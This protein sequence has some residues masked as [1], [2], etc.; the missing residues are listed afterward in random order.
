MKAERIL[1]LLAVL[2]CV[3]CSDNDHTRTDEDT[4]TP[5]TI[6]DLFPRYHYYEYLYLYQLHVVLENTTTGK[7]KEFQINEKGGLI[8]EIG[9]G[10]KMPNDAPY[11]FC[12]QFNAVR[13]IMRN[14]VCYEEVLKRYPDYFYYECVLRFENAYELENIETKEFNRFNIHEA[15]RMLRNPNPEWQIPQKAPYVL[16]FGSSMGL[17]LYKISEICRA[18]SAK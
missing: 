1:L 8:D 5:I 2:F 17:H 13:L 16:D 14:E 6:E 7:T 10:W 3:A 4:D 9:L 11:L 18:L 12:K 15:E